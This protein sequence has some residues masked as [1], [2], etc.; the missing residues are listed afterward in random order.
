MEKVKAKLK[1][2]LS[3]LKSDW[4]IKDYPLRLK[5][6]ENVP[7][8]LKYVYQIINWW[9]VTGIGKDKDEAYR[10]LNE[11]FELL[12]AA[13]SFKPRPGVTQKMEF[14]STQIV[15][16]YSDLLDHFIE[17]ILGFKKDD[18]VFISDESSLWD[19]PISDEEEFQSYLSK[20]EKTYNFV[21]ED[22][23][24]DKISDIIQL[25]AENRGDTAST[26]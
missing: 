13:K 23:N 9:T 17:N 26:G 25:I 18:P 19:F 16:K 4:T 1:Y 22:K 20:I 15:D 21:I 7:V 2:F 14:A 8:E 11:S 5:T 12:V 6:Q 10:K 3:F 24:V